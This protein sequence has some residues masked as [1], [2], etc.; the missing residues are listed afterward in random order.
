MLRFSICAALALLT[1]NAA[2]QESRS[3]RDKRGRKLA[4]RSALF[5]LRRACVP[6][7]S[8]LR[9]YACAHRPVG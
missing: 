4:S 8:L 3:G 6:D 7:A 2:A 5:T 1:S 9:G